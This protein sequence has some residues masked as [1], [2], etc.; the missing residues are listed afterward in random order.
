MES[1]ERQS[2]ELLVDDQSTDDDL[3]ALICDPG[4][5]LDCE[6]E[7]A[8]DAILAGGLDEEGEPVGRFRRRVVE[9]GRPMAVFSYFSVMFGIP[10]FLVPFA[11]RDNEF[12]LHHARAAGVAYIACLTMLALSLTQCAVFLPLVFLC[13]IPALIGVY[14]ASAGVEAG[15]SALGPAGERIFGRIEVKSES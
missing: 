1:E 3:E 2:N 9:E 5:E 11:L 7:R 13:Y 10:V 14:R 8:A 15:T 4:D 12:A 6:L